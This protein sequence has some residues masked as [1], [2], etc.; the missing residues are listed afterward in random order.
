M[1]LHRGRRCAHARHGIALILPRIA[2][3]RTDPSCGLPGP[4]GHPAVTSMPQFTFRRLAAVAVLAL[5]CL[6]GTP[7][8]A[9][10]S[11]LPVETATD[12][13][14]SWEVRNRFRLFRDEKDF[15]RHLA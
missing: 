7:A 12:V 3:P 15:N 2:S 5:L 4:V 9:Q 6:H 10:L 13:R 8:R 1:E 11:I 14:I